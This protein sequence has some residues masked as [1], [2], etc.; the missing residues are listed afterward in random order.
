MIHVLEFKKFQE[1]MFAYPRLEATYLA[2]Y[3]VGSR[4]LATCKRHLQSEYINSTY[5]SSYCVVY[6]SSSYHVGIIG[7]SVPRV[8]DS[9]YTSNVHVSHPNEVILAHYLYKM[10]TTCIKMSGNT[11]NNKTMIMCFTIMKA[12]ITKR[13]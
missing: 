6:F 7:R 11:T 2:W 4:V 12:K 1:K 5:H 9:H 13:A 8:L 10:K 3:P